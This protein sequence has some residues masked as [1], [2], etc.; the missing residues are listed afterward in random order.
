M[1]ASTNG[2]ATYTPIPGATNGLYTTPTLTPADNGN[3]YE[4]VFSNSAGSVTSQPAVLTVHYVT[5][6]SSPTSQT[7]NAGSTATF[8]ASANSDATPAVQW[9]GS[10]DGGTTFVA[11]GGATSTSYTTPAL[12][13]A[14]DGNQYEARFNNNYGDYPYT[15]LATVTVDYAPMITTSPTSQSASAGTGITLTAAAERNPD[16]DGAVAKSTDG[17]ATFTPI[18]GATSA[19]YTTPNLTTAD[20]GTLYEAVFTNSRGS[21]TTNSATISVAA[22]PIVATAPAAVTTGIGSTATF[23]VAA[24]GTPMPTVQWLQSTDGGATFTPISGATS[25]SY[26]TPN[27]TTADNGTRYEASFTNTGGTTVTAPATLTVAASSISATDAAGVLGNDPAL[28][29]GTVITLTISYLVPNATYSLTLHSTPIALGS[30]TANGAGTA[31]Y[32]LTIPAGLAAG[33]HTVAVTDAS[34]NAGASYAFSVAGST[35]LAKTGTNISTLIVVAIGLIILGAAL[36]RRPRRR[37]S[38]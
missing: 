36:T 28:A 20:N 4:A 7:V 3:R 10:S 37:A 38:R 15:T 31:T 11:I 23:T 6:A 26:T 29:P 8:T 14:D 32:Q 25:A 2:G 27:L 17:G 19:S 5:I 21:A 24:T 16:T 9:F 12:T 18:S 30:I 34:G 1:A 35:A 33:A 22:M 13:A